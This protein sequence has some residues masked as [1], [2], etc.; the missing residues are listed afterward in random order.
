LYNHL[1][2]AGLAIEN[3]QVLDANGTVTVT[4][5]AQ[6]GETAAK[7]NEL[8]TAK[9]VALVTNKVTIADL[10]HLNLQ[11]K[12]ATNASNLNCRKGASTNDEIVGKFPEDSVV[13]LVQKHNATWYKV[14]GND[15]EGYCH[16]D[17]LEQIN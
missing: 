6:D 11:Y 10:S 13:T 4:G 3:L 16:T 8:L 9:G 17:Y 15:I 2:E 5:V 14:K 1:K 7:V 12:V